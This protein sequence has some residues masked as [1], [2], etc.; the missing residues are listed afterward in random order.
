VVAGEGPTPEAYWEALE[1]RLPTF[2][3]EE[4]RAAVC[5]Y[6]ELS[7]GQPVDAAQFAEALRISDQESVAVLK[8]PSIESLTHLGEDGRVT[9]FGGLAV[10]PTRHVFEVGGRAL[11]TWCAWDALFIPE[12]LD[13]PARVTSRDPESGEL[14]RLV[15]GRGGIELADPGDVVVSFVAPE[16]EVFETSAGNL[17]AKFCHFIFFFSSRPSGDRWVRN[18]PGTSLY[19]LTDAFELAKR[20]NA[21]TFGLELARLKSAGADAA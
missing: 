7:K 19:A 6:R 9:G 2:S 16:A 4:Q 20:M 15:V 10:A 11:G 12:L 1:P 21:R 13:R 14:V 5:L 17:M 3:T 18:H 8:R